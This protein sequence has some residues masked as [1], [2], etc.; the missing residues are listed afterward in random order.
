MSEIIKLTD[1]CFD[2]IP[3]YILNAL[4]LA[5]ITLWTYL[6]HG[7]PAK[8]RTDYEHIDGV[9]EA[10]RYHDHGDHATDVKSNQ[11]EPYTSEHNEEPQDMPRRGPEQVHTGDHLMSGHSHM[12]HNS[13]ERLMFATITIAVCHCGAG[14]LLGDI[15]GEWLVYGTGLEINGSEMRAEFL[16]G[17]WISLVVCP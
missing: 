10:H 14:C 6:K 1:M 17:Q 15:V 13:G 3:V 5:P 7:R 2:R 11:R 4:Y 9:V 16:A 12:Q 8:I